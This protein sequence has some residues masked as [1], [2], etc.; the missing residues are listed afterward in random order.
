MKWDYWS[1]AQNA[2]AGIRKEL[3][4]VVGTLDRA[5]RGREMW[6]LPPKQAR[7]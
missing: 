1:N 5:R 7:R 6:L 3:L 4:I 2:E